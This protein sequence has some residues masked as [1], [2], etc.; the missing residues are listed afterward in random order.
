[1][2]ERYFTSYNKLSRI[3]KVLPL[4]LLFL[5][6]FAFASEKSEK[7]KDIDIICYAT[8]QKWVC[9]PETEKQL[10]NEKAEKLIKKYNEEVPSNIVIKSIDIPKFTEQEPVQDSRQ[11]F[12][13]M[14]SPRRKDEPPPPE[15]ANLKQQ[16]AM[17][18][19]S[20]NQGNPYA[21]L[22]SHQLIGVSTP[23]QAVRYVKQMG[24]DRQE[25]LIIKSVR[26]G[27]DWWIV[28]LGL[29][30]DKQTGKNNEINLPDNVEQAW[31]RPLKNLDV[32]GFIE[33]F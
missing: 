20:H 27:H 24:L 13:N 6:F 32:R 11:S 12:V 26:N 4:N 28:L 18:E 30:K 19:V 3:I 16:S 25:I 33:D 31:L 8:P 21:K 17:T 15:D 9:A 14:L 23:Q 2:R 1:M 22:W 7:N 5:S 29:Y 10:A